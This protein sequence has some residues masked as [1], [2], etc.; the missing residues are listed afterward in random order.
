[1]H[2]NKAWRFQARQ[3]VSQHADLLNYHGAGGYAATQRAGAALSL[4]APLR[5]SARGVSHLS[6]NPSL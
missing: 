2:L 4:E 5:P 3:V 1:M 6:L